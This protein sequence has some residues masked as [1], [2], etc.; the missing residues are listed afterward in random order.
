MNEVSYIVDTTLQPQNCFGIRILIS[1]LRPP[2]MKIISTPLLELTLICTLFHDCWSKN[3][4]TLRFAPFVPET[5]WWY[6]TAPVHLALCRIL[7]FPSLLWNETRFKFNN[8]RFLI[9]KQMQAL[10]KL[11]K[12][13]SLQYENVQYEMDSGYKNKKVGL[14]PKSLRPFLRISYSR[15]P[16]SQ[17]IILIKSSFIRIKLTKK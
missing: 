10:F 12:N 2:L 6:L 4:P 17:W 16:R 15:R 7:Y 8:Y 3:L 14:N 13:I 9:I 11:S 5:P 1:N